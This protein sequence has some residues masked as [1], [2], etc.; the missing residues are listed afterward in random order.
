MSSCELLG[1]L[2][3]NK[4]HNYLH[5]YSGI[6]VFQTSKGNEN[7]FG[8]EVRVIGRFEKMRV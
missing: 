3:V 4:V 5:T 1:A 8:T 2:R 7:W 6:P